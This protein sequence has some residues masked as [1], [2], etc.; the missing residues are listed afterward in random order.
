MT[1]QILFAVACVLGLNCS[2]QTWKSIY[3]STKTGEKLQLVEGKSKEVYLA[4]RDF[5]TGKANV[6]VQK[7]GVWSWVGDST[8]SPQGIANLKL[9]VA[10][11]SMPVVAFQDVSKDFQLTVMK[12]NGTKWD[13]LGKRAF[14]GFTGAGEIG[15]ACGGN[16]IFAA[17]QQYNQIKV[18]VWNSTNKVWDYVGSNGIASIG[19][20]SGCEL[21]V[22][23]SE[24]YV[25]YR[26][27]PGS[28]EVRKTTISDAS[29]SSFWYTVKSTFGSGQNG[30]V[31]ITD[32]IG[33]P[34]ASNIVTASKYLNSWIYGVGKWNSTG[35]PPY[36]MLNYD[37]TDGLADSFPVVAFI[38]ADN[39]GRI[40][41]ANRMWQWDSL[42]NSSKFTSDVLKGTVEV[43]YTSDQRILV[44]YE[45]NADWKF[46]IREYCPSLNGTVISHSGP[47]EFCAGVSKVLSVKAVSA[48]VQWLR[49]GVVL[50]GQTAT[51][52]S[53]TTSGSYAARLK[54]FCGDS[55]TTAAIAITV[56]SN[57]VP[58]IVQNGN[59]LETQTFL[60]YEWYKDDVKLTGE[61]NRTYTPSN[62][63]VYTVKVLSA[64]MCMGTSNT[65]TF[66][67]ASIKNLSTNS[68]VLYPN[69]V[70][71]ILNIEVKN[72]TTVTLYNLAGKVLLTQFISESATVNMSTFP[73]GCYY[74]K[75]SENEIQKIVKQ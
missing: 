66:W 24:V 23:G 50:S 70:N 73:A 37:I 6:K 3:A 19:F 49:N 14:S 28:N 11:D 18:W 2:A 62:G 75:S 43:L 53:P 35:F 8:F 51:S 39:Y 44:A 69:P 38:S 27:N 71:E 65:Y 48:S 7:N 5:Q 57:P 13:T 1:K 20:P 55:V 74:I 58:T 67:P 54:N 32:V 22:I 33:M 72:P 52:F 59:I 61:T 9:A 60:A 63:G 26:T 42:G 47:T 12:F 31:R 17:Y 21:K 16:K 68:L 10:D 45:K 30:A 25:G 29:P 36:T 64:Q 40:F 4:F 46:E 15:L 56:H 41:R 34:M